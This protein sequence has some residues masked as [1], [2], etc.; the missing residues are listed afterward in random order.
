MVKKFFL[1]LLCAFMIFGGLNHFLNTDIYLSM[2]P[3]YLPYHLELVFLSGIAEIICG[4]L[5]PIPKTRVWGAWFTILTLIA[6]FPANVYMAQNPEL[7]LFA[8]K[9]GL[10]IR[11]PFQFVLIGWAS[12]YVKKPD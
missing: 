5:L 6:I 11:L 12:L 10:Y 1:Y 3:P 2:M 8:S 7:F 4:V 9:L